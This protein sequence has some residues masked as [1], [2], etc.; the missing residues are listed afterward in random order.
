[1][2]D[3]VGMP[4]VLHKIADTVKNEASI[5]AAA[6]CLRRGELVVFPTETVYGLGANALDPIAVQK[7][8]ALK[9]R[10]S[11]NPLIVHVADPAQAR[12][13]VREWP[14][15]AEALA[16]AFW[17][18]PLTLVLPKA[19]AIPPQVTAG[20][21]T[22]ALRVPAH[23]VALALLRHAQVPVAAPS[24]NRSGEISP[25]RAEHVL[26]S[27]GERVAEVA[28]ILDAG[29]TQVGL[30]STVVSLVG[31]PRL[32]RPG[33]LSRERIEAVLGCPLRLVESSEKTG[34][35]PSPGMLR[36]HY[37]PRTRMELVESADPSELADRAAAGERL[38]WMTQRDGPAPPRVVVQRMPQSAADYA[39]RLYDVLHALDALGLD[40]IIVD[41]PPLG[42]DWQAIHDRLARAAAQD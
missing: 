10:P 23:P 3:A 37:S 14:E 7:I 26:R 4:Q 28:M 42:A 19:D 40:R 13:L 24:A 34:P 2:G 32:L 6:A 22:V 11:N 30:E 1:M 39:A 35:L 15:S 21:P 9:G 25:T 29:P 38:G 36:R 18:G 5:R 16:K 12:E 20:G 41:L 31:E 27:L 17:P 33:Q 8:F